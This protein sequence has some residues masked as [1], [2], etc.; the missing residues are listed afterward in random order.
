[1]NY[2][3]KLIT[4]LLGV[5]LTT[6]IHAKEEVSVAIVNGTPISQ[7]TL[8]A[9]MDVVKRTSP[10]E[11]DIQSALDDLVVTELAIQQAHREG[12]EKRED[13]QAK[14]K[15]AARKILLTTWTQE[16]SKKLDI[17]DEDMKK[18]YDDRMKNQAHDEYHARHILV[19]TED[20]AKAIITELAAGGDFEKLAKEKSIGPSK[21]KGGDLGWFK[22]GTMVKPFAEA[23]EGMEEGKVSA[24]PVKT[25]FGFHIIKLE[26]KRGAKLPSF[27]Q[28]KSQM[29]RLLTQKKMI[30]YINALKDDADI[31]ITL[32]ESML[33]VKKENEKSESKVS[34]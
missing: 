8:Q 23:V 13:V 25:N 11:V 18:L 20:E 14:I 30:E 3:A 26:A 29:K 32:P 28:L 27:E 22:S 10:N 24:E 21:V 15:D 4:V 2:K 9:Y 33:E 5:S 34:E 12:M 17:T 7:D 31:K 16:K 1:M 19:K 6:V